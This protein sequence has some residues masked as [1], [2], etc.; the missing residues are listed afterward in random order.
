MA[1]KQSVVDYLLE[2][3]ADAGPMTARKMFGEYGVY[4]GPKVIAL[5]CDDEL[6]IKPTGPGRA[7]LG[8]VDERPAYP[9]GKPWFWIAGMMASGWRRWCG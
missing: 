4:C 6:F 1:S 3:M 9:G 2:Q 5:V 8:E 7:L